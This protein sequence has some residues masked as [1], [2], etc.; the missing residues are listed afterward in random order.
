MACGTGKTYTSLKIAEEEVNSKGLVLFLVPSIALLGQTLNEWT[1]HAGTPLRPMCVCSDADVSK[2]Q[3]LEDEGG[4]SV[5][6]LAFP[7]STS[8]EQIVR[9]FHELDL[10]AKTNGQLAALARES[11]KK[12]PQIAR[13]RQITNEAP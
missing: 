9:Q 1:S 7:A 12:M 8:V 4:F 13:S 10:L 6:D 5:E 3:K 2:K 11:E